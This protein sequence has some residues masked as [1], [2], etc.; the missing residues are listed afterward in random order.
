MKTTLLET[1]RRSQSGRGRWLLLI[2]LLA[3]P[4]I[5]FGAPRPTPS[6]S[7]APEQKL[8]LAVAA[9]VIQHAIA[10]YQTKG[11]PKLE[12]ADLT[13]KVTS[14]KT[15]GGSFTFWI[16]TI[17]ATTTE[18]KVQTVAFNYKVPGSDRSTPSSP[19][20]TASPKP[21]PTLTPTAT[22]AEVTTQFNKEFLDVNTLTN[23]DIESFAEKDV[24]IMA[25]SVAALN[26]SRAPNVKQFEDSLIALIDEA[27]KAAEKTPKIGGAEFQTFAVSIDYSVKF[28][29]SVGA[30]IPV[31]QV[32]TIGPKAS[33]N[34]DTAHTLKL[35][36]RK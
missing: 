2:F 27:A 3:A 16:I 36:F 1:L 14:G 6:A 13:F 23:L 28:E 31:L 4:L 18:T 10:R 33:F 12:S 35:T 20:V 11:I 7:P 8:E 17:G 15:I 32:L 29:G 34:R 24:N 21:A 9:T 26:G 30:S 5:A 22:P 25:Q 19:P